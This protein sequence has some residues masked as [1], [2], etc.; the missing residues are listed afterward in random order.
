[1]NVVDGAVR[2]AGA[3]A[4]VEAAG[5]VRWPLAQGPGTEGQSVA[6][7][8]RPEHLTLGASGGVPGEI[9][10]VEP[11]GAET[12]LVIQVGDA[13]IN[14]RIHGRP[15]VNPGDKVSLA[16]DPANVHVFDK[17]TGQRLQN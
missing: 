1:M 14:L 8:I 7:G 4:H 3:A 13:S 10:V 16:I 11:T 5:G 12:E 2:R 6:Y 15:R 9:V 17:T